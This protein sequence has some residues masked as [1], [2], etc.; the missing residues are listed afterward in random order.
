MEAKENGKEW[1]KSRTVWFNVLAFIVAVAAEF[2]YTG[3]LPDEWAVFVPAAVAIINLILR[4]LTKE[5][6]H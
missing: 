5:P 6:I 4:W 2:G 3:E 1:W